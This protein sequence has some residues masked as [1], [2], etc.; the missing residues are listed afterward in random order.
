MTTESDKTAFDL[1]SMSILLGG[2]AW[3][4]PDGG[5]FPQHPPAGRAGEAV[6]PPERDH[7]I[8]ESRDAAVVI[9]SGARASPEP[10]IHRA[11]CATRCGQMS[12]GLRQ[13]QCRAA[14]IASDRPRTP[15]FP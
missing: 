11:R 13:P 10:V 1:R 9:P 15:S 3:I 5:P 7:H 12:S 6:A 2:A 4:H 8:V 14:L